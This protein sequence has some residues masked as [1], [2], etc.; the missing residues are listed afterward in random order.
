LNQ[1]V[2]DETENVRSMTTGGTLSTNPGR[3]VL[4]GIAELQPAAALELQGVGKHYERGKKFI[5]AVSDI[6]LRVLP[7]EVYGFLGPNGAGK[8][9]TI[10]MILGLIHPTH[11]RVLV[12]GEEVGLG[13]P[14]SRVGSLVDGGSFYPFLSGRENLRVLARTR[15]SDPTRIEMLLEKVDLASASDAKV[16]GYSLGM[17][18]RLGV[19]AALLSDPDLVVLDEPSNG[20]DAAG[21][22]DMRALVRSLAKEGKAVFLSSHL[23]HEVQ[24]VC[25]R[26]AIV[27]KGRAVREATIE[28]LLSQ[29]NGVNVVA[30]P[31]EDAA[32]ALRFL[33]PVERCGSS[34]RV[35]AD[36]ADIPDI[37]REL[38][39]RGIDIHSV[40]VDRQNL[41]Q[42]FLNMTRSGDD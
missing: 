3:S 5:R 38:V 11:G 22:Q 23:L 16:K 28:E 6:S 8:S 34:L 24:Q 1:F 2:R 19:A 17:R 12:Y 15:G 10:R 25:D 20:L 30:S 29:E 9:T 36:K 7:G 32:N 4:T 39:V 37:V 14:S 41:E 42:I 26:V 13:R 18:Q 40:G 33:W 27:A 31:L 21:I 35:A